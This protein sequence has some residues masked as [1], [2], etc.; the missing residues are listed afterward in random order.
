M[1]SN[2]DIIKLSDDYN[3]LGDTEG[4]IDATK[5]DLILAFAFNNNDIL[6]GLTEE[7]CEL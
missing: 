6:E 1:Q 7:P 2:S 4:Q 5:K 3:G